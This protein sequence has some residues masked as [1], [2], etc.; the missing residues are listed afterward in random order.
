MKNFEDFLSV[1]EVSKHNRF[2]GVCTKNL[3]LENRIFVQ[4]CYLKAL[5]F[6]Y[7]NVARTIWILFAHSLKCKSVC[8]I[9]LICKVPLTFFMLP[10]Y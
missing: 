2:C 10:L 6:C 4:E 5:E 1:N 7:E 8:S 9:Q 3:V